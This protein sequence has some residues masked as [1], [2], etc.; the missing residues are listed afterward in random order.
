MFKT[1]EECEVVLVQSMG[2]DSMPATA[3]RVSFG[4][5][6]LNAGVNTRDEK[7]INYLAEHEHNSCFEHQ[8]ATFMIECPT[9]IRTQIQRHRTFSYNEISRRY[10]DENIEFW[11]PT[12]WRKQSTDN[13]QASEGRVVLPNGEDN[14]EW[15]VG[16]SLG[17][18][19]SL[20]D[21]GVA[22][23][24]AR[25]ILPQSLLTRFYMTGNLRNYAHYLKLRM[26]EHSQG[27]VRVIAQ[28]QYDLLHKVWPVS[29]EALMK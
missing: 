22:R 12:T 28:K 18:Y 15:Y 20:L 10:T 11:K 5:D 19:Q 24:Q 25:A 8:T 9:Y 26:S 21:Q 6:E 1:I 7:L 27:E 14:W 16:V 13:K 29:M 23:E 17:Y 4:K 3:A 2:D